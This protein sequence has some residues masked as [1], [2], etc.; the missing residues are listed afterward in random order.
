MPP[1]RV[2]SDSPDDHPD[3]RISCSRTDTI[4]GS[5][6]WWG[7][8]ETSGVGVSESGGPLQW[9]VGESLVGPPM[10]VLDAVIMAA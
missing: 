8:G 1:S 10:F 4:Q 3:L 7:A 2:W 6:A 9:P 5:V